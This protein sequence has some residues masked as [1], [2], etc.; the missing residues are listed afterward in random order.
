MADST[1]FRTFP[2]LILKPTSRWI[3]TSCFRVFGVFACVL[4]L[5]DIKDTKDDY[6][7]ISEMMNG[8]LRRGHSPAHLKE[9]QETIQHVSSTSKTGNASPE[10]KCEKPMTEATKPTEKPLQ[11]V[12]FELPAKK[13]PVAAKWFAARKLDNTPTPKRKRPALLPG[14]RDSLFP[15]DKKSKTENEAEEVDN[16]LGDFEEPE[17]I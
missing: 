16:S 1:C 17:T 4:A 11:F 15:L 3:L 14:D 9:N 12:P 7:Q 8:V 10:E 13:H 5:K 2:P 6:E